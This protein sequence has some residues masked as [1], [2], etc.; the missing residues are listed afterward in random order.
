MEKKPFQFPFPVSAEVSTLFLETGLSKCFQVNSSKFACGA[1]FLNDAGSLVF[2][3]HS[4]DFFNNMQLSNPLVFP[5]D[6]K[7]IWWDSQQR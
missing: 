6:F 2:L 4:I 7:C 3:N 1:H 5:S